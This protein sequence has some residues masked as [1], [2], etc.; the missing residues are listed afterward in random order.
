MSLARR[1]VV[2]PAAQARTLVSVAPALVPGQGAAIYSPGGKLLEGGDLLFHPGLD[3]ALAA[4]ADEGPD[5]FYTGRYG[6]VL[7][8]TVQAGGGAIGP[9]DLSAYRVL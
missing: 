4:L 2:L 3:K 6:E 5:I 8:D 7:V 1:G 9:A